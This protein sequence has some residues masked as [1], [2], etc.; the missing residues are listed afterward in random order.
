MNVPSKWSVVRRRAALG[1][2]GLLVAASLVALPATAAHAA[3]SCGVNYTTNTWVESPGAGGFTANITINNLGDPVTAWTLR[4]AFPGSQTLTPPGWSANWSQSGQNMTAT[5]LDWNRTLATGG[6]TTIGF[7]G[8]WTGSNPNPTVF[9]L[10]NVTCTGGPPPVNQPPTVSL[11]SPASGQSF[12]AGSAVPLAANASDPDGTVNRVEFLVDGALAGTDTSSPYSFSATGL[13]S[14]NHTAAARAVDNGNPALSTTTAAVTFTVGGGGTPAIVASPNPLNLVEGGTASLN[15]RLS[16]A[17]SANV[18]VTL[19][20]TGDTNITVSPTSITLTPSNF[21]G[22]VNVTVAAAEDADQANDTASIAAAGTGVTGTTVSVTATD[23]DGG[24][25]GP[26]VDNPFVGATGYASADYANKLE[27]SA[28]L[29]PSTTAAKLRAL[30][31]VPTAVW[32]DRIGAI[33][34]TPTAM[35]LRAHLN[36]A[37]AQKQGSTPITATFVVYDLP[38]RDCAALASNG[39]LLIAQNGLNRYKTEYIDRI[40]SIVADPAYAGVRIVLIVEPDSIPNLVTNLSTPACAEAEQTG[41]YV[42]GVRYAISKLTVPDNTYLYLDV[43]HSGWL[44]WPN[45]FDGAVNRYQQL[46]NSPG[47]GW[48]SI[49]GFISNTANYTPVE[50]P[51]LPNPDL[52]VGGDRILN[53]TFYEFNPNFDERDF[54]TALRNRFVSNGAPSTIGMLIDTSRNGWGGTARPTAVSTSTDRN[55]YVNQSKIDRRPHRG[56]WCNQN[57]AGIGFRPTATPFAGVDAYVW[58]KPPGESDGV[59]DPGIIDPDDPAK[60]FDAMCD[61][62]AQNRYNNAFPTNALPGAPHAG[63]W[64]H[65]QIVMLVTN[66]FP[67]L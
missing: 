54:V 64:F 23:N 22:G 11:T 41:A 65:D 40:A 30:K 18:T 56:G 39:E 12:P 32:L 47:P 5:P 60:K 67:A 35:G 48:A 1:G 59:S 20:K 28:V 34:G 16:S 53:T 6:S 55:T 50:E 24:G 45:N 52:N 10:N 62:D 66:A 19:T 42:E 49:D 9:T 13:T 25:G 57:G 43:A 63:R 8:R 15:V 37:V 21:S 58:V 2:A 14:G 61:P 44:G 4:F 29:V 36:A 3:V 33:D 51:F 46:I 26:H 27:G 31:T 7:N 38:N 17:P